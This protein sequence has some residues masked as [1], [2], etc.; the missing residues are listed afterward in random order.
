MPKTYFLSLVASAA[1]RLHH[2]VRNVISVLVGQYRSLA[3]NDQKYVL[4]IRGRGFI[5]NTAVLKHIFKI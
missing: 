3:T 5:A 1:A 2:D 4:G